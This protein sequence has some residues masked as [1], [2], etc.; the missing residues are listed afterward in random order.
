MAKAKKGGAAEYRLLITPYFDERRQL[1][2]TLFLLETVQYF[3][4]FQYELSVKHEVSGK[5]ISIHVLGLNAPQLS[6]PAAGHAS[7]EHHYDKLNGTYELTVKGIDGRVNVFSV[8]IDSKKVQLLGA[9]A[10]KF[11]EV[12]VDEKLW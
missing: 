7:F 4:S 9:P 6:L 1:Q 2:T 12:V 11:V 10:E 5:A 3:A 8:K